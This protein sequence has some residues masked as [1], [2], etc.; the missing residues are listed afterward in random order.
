MSLVALVVNFLHNF[1][2]VNSCHMTLLSKIKARKIHSI[3]MKI[4]EIQTKSVIIKTKILI[5]HYQKL[6]NKQNI[7]IVNTIY[8]NNYFCKI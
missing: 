4:T 8:H 1:L 3:Q 7:T 6:K 2:L 5:N